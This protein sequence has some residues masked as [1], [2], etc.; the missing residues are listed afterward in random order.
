MYCF[1]HFKQVCF[2]Y[3]FILQFWETL[4]LKQIIL[5]FI[6]LFFNGK[7]I[8]HKPFVV[9]VNVVEVFLVVVVSLYVVVVVDVDVVVVEVFMVVVVDVVVKPIPP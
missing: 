6:L 2:L 4:F 3:F 1:F 9:E 7:I 5:V 8:L